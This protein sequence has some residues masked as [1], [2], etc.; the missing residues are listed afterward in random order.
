MPDTSAAR[1]EARQPSGEFGTKVPT[2]QELPALTP[3]PQA[4]EQYRVGHLVAALIG[5]GFT[6]VTDDGDYVVE[7][8]EDADPDYD[9]EGEDDLSLQYAEEDNDTYFPQNT[10]LQATISDT[11]VVTK[12]VTF[13][14]STY[15]GE[16]TSDET[17]HLDPSGKFGSR[18]EDYRTMLTAAGIS[19]E[20]Q[21]W[22][23]LPRMTSS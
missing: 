16:I 4:Q 10:V 6:R 20:E 12:L 13:M 22:P 2:S 11:G 21:D 3:T 14:Q 1:E 15:D 9:D 23:R 5:A 19:F 7:S 17:D 18:G 8:V